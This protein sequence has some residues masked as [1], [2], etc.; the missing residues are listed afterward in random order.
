MDFRTIGFGAALNPATKA[1]VS[2][3]GTQIQTYSNGSPCGSCKYYQG[4]KEDYGNCGVWSTKMKKDVCV[5]KTW[6]CSRYKPKVMVSQLGSGSF[7]KALLADG[8]DVTPG[9][10]P[11]SKTGE[12]GTNVKLMRGGKVFAI[13]N[14]GNSV[15]TSL[16]EGSHLPISDIFTFKSHGEKNG[17]WTIEGTTDVVPGYFDNMLQL[18]NYRF[19][20][21]MTPQVYTSVPLNISWFASDE[22]L[23]GTNASKTVKTRRNVKR[24]GHNYVPA[25]RVTDLS[26]QLIVDVERP[27]FTEPGHEDHRITRQMIIKVRC[28]HA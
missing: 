13:V 8:R 6:T 11:W 14:F 20:F 2:I 25:G 5:S 9:D 24:E 27:R 3:E 1:L 28:R 7:S 4:G 23:Y 19:S 12:Y 16:R 22:A 18:S 15:R 26:G 21:S 10:A 17:V